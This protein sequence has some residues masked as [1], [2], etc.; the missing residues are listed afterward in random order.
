MRGAGD[1]LLTLRRGSRD[2]A[3][4]AA[5]RPLGRQSVSPIRSTP[6]QERGRSRIR[7]WA[8]RAVLLLGIALLTTGCQSNAFTRQGLLPPVTRQ[9]QVILSMWQGS[10]IAAWIVGILVW[11]GILWTVIFHRKRGDHLPR[12]VRYNLP[13]EILYTVLPFIMVGVLF[14]FTAKDESYL[15][16][17]PKH[18]DVRVHVIGEQWTWQ[19]IYPQYQAAGGR[20]VTEVGDM[21]RPGSNQSRLP[22]LVI[23]TNETVQFTL[24]SIDVVHSFWIP[25][26]EFKRDLIPGPT[27]R[28]TGL[29]ASRDT[30]QANF[31]VTPDKTGTF[32]GHCSE[33]CGVY[34]SR[35]LFRVKIVTPARF[36]Q[37]I[38]AQQA[39]Q[40]ASGGAS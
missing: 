9:G 12:Q 38:K 39:Q 22:L 10:W 26:F 14:F 4:I 15:N 34:H 35:M 25:P 7:R 17:I 33:L 23:P 40:K 37:W 18:P 2:Q 27:P 6:R 32:I 19:F 29:E 3:R 5:V 21:W 36:Q 24:T 20:P 8:P 16:K 30:R 11:G 28:R 13:I 31:T 1:R